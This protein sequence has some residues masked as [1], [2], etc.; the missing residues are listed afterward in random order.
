MIAQY[1]E[2][3]LDLRGKI[4]GIVRANEL[5]SRHTSFGVGGPADLYAE[6]ASAED[7][8]LLVKEA[9]RLEIPWIVIGD[10]QNLLVSDGGVR[11]LV[12]RLGRPMA[13]IR[14]EGS[15][16]VVGAAAKLAKAIDAAIQHSLAGLEGVT[17]VPGS[18]GGAV[19]MNAGTRY[20][21]IGDVT[22]AVTVVSPDGDIERLDREQL[23]FTYRYCALQE[24]TKIVTDVE[25][26]LRP[27]DKAELVRMSEH[28]RRRRTTTQPTVGRSAGCVFRNPPDGHAS[29]L[30]DL[31]GAKGMREGDAEV[32]DKHANFILNMGSANAAQ[33]RSLAERVREMVREKHGLVLEYEVRMIGDWEDK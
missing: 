15:R 12:I 13:Y 11:G 6:P 1:A 16:M 5:M 22:H 26:D 28:L 10:G 25:M 32:S 20:G 17:G 29:Q 24:D 2:L 31:A 7:V 9:A 21:S 33:I 30:I 4:N 3:A 23:G 18:V 27:G 8:S 19:F 14:V